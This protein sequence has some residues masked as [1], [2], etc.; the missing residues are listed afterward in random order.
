MNI[1]FLKSK[2]T[3]ATVAAAAVLGV[4]IAT[5]E[6]TKEDEY[7]LGDF[8]LD[9]PTLDI[10]SLDL[11][12]LDL[13][14]LSLGIDGV[15]VNGVSI[16]DVSINGVS[17]N[18]GGTTVPG[19]SIPRLNVGDVS[20]ADL[21]LVELSNTKMNIDSL[22]GRFDDFKVDVE[23]LQQYV[24]FRKL[25]EK[26]LTDKRN[27]MYDSTLTF[28]NK[29][30]LK[31]LAIYERYAEGEFGSIEKVLL[32]EFR[33]ITEVHPTYD[34][35]ALKILDENL[36]YYKAEG[37]DSV[38]V[39]F[40]AENQP[41]DVV[42]IIQYIKSKH[43]MKVFLTYTD[44]EDL[45]VSVFC[46]PVTYE[47][48]LTACAPLIDG[49]LNAWRRTSAHLLKQDDAFMA[50]TNYVLRKYNSKLPIIGELYFG[51]TWRFEG[52]KKFG[53]ETNTFA[54]Q[55]ALNI[56]NFG[57]SNVDPSVLI[58]RF[59]KD[60]VKGQ[61]IVAT[62]VGDTAYYASSN[63]NGL[64]QAENMLKKH[65]IENDFISAGCIG[66][67]TYQDDALSIDTNN[68]CKTL[69]NKIDGK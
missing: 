28:K 20:V 40:T 59:I 69:Y 61:Q 56:V 58:K 51:N 39:C 3:I 10:P 62:V 27:L 7:D 31:W 13:P 34:G 68:L 52:H 67:I 8:D 30:L 25:L 4:G 26:T 42:H 57:Y 33:M 5:Y 23:D 37:Y 35:S 29:N 22:V 41:I 18:V 43:K 64:S 24:E 45:K 53:F 63:K 11:P 17:V 50:F 54:N 47:S 2:K 19:M 21:D 16:N 44:K 49:Y 48:I 9:I 6:L 46:D 32:K 36:A 38:L 12:S 15:S 14:D 66:V 1:D 55:S 60:Y 65:Q